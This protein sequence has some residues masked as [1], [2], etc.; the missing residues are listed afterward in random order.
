MIPLQDARIPQLRALN[1][2]LHAAAGFR[3]EPVAGLVSPRTFMR[4]LGQRVF[5]STQYIRHHSKP[6]Y[7]PEPDVLHELIDT[8]RRWSTRGSPSSTAC[9]GSRPPWRRT[10]RWCGSSGRT[11]TRW[12]LGSWRSGATSRAYGA[13]LLS[14]IGELSDY[15]TKPRLEGW[16]LDTIADTPYDPTNYQDVLFVAPSFTR[17]LVDVTIWVRTGGWR[18]DG[19]DRP[20]LSPGKSR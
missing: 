20:L 9:W 4:Y 18:A 8:R 2:S 16:N 14:S 11:G 3:M 7:T 17:M 13:G 19:G 10:R 1:P 15:D 6:L 12:S 5:L